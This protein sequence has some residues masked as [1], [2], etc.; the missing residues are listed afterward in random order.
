MELLKINVWHKLVFYETKKCVIH[1]KDKMYCSD[2]LWMKLSHV[3][4]IL[5]MRWSPEHYIKRPLS[6]ESAHFM[7]ILLWI[8]TV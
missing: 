1:F 5:R 8:T 2:T 6:A 4:K 7:R 3:R